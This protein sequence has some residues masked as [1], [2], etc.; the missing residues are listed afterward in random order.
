MDDKKQRNDAR[1]RL[2]SVILLCCDRLKI[3]RP[4]GIFGDEPEMNW[5]GDEPEKGFYTGV[6]DEVAAEFDAMS[7]SERSERLCP[8][9]PPTS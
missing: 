8:E 1:M 7:L 3:E 4:V 6:F 2:H 9:V 5:D